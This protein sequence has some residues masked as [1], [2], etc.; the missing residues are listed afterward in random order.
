ME[1]VDVGRACGHL[2]QKQRD[3]LEA[4]AVLV[5]EVNQ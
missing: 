4:F 2:N 3:V 5:R 1:E